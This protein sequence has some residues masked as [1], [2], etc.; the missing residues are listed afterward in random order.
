MLYCVSVLSP[1]IVLFLPNFARTKGEAAEQLSSRVRGQ[2]GGPDSGNSGPSGR[3]VETGCSGTFLAFPPCLG[4][5]SARSEMPS[6]SIPSA[7]VAP[8][9]F[10]RKGV[11]TQCG[12]P[13]GFAPSRPPAEFDSDKRLGELRR[14]APR[15]SKW[16]SRCLALQ[17]SAVTLLAGL[18]F[19]CTPKHRKEFGRDDPGVD[20]YSRSCMY[21]EDTY[22]NYPGRG[23]K[24]SFIES[25]SFRLARI[26]EEPRTARCNDGA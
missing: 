16:K 26:R 20:G 12:S 18:H 24:R 23:W 5:P 6:R 11:H 2:A 4:V 13:P 15:C 22:I 10:S 19:P 21:R 25:G 17:R 8:F 9:L 1:S 7:R 14:K 3:W